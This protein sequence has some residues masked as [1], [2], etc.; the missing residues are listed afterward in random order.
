[1]RQTFSQW[2]KQWEDA[3][4]NSVS[5]GGISMPADAMSKDKHKKHKKANSYDGRTREGRKFVER[6]MSKRAAR[7]ATKSKV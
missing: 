2:N 7:E 4:A 5:A 1:M 6:I 3:A